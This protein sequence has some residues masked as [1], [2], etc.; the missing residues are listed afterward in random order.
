M[1]DVFD[2][3]ENA[4]IELPCCCMLLIAVVEIIGGSFLRPVLRVPVAIELNVLEG[5]C[6]V[7][8]LDEDDFS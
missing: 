3:C 2:F 4:S 8:E 6:N 1:V 7:D 5:E